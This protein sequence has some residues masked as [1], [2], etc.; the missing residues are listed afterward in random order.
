[1][2]VPL[3][4][5]TVW[6]SRP[7]SQK[8]HGDAARRGPQPGENPQRRAGSRDE[9][10]LNS[11]A[12]A[13]GQ[14]IY[15]GEGEYRP[16]NTDPGSRLLGHELAHTVQQQSGAKAILR[17]G[18]DT[19]QQQPPITAQGIIGLPQGSHVLVGRTMEDFIFGVG[20]AQCAIRGG[21]AGDQ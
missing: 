15:F 18:K 12:F 10:V 17:Q 14:S 7:T 1:M 19:P 16:K 13:F 8:A 5:G 21:A 9:P 4:R 11:R 6:S 3:L 20:G 2:A